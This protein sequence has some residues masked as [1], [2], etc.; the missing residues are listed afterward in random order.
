MISAG[1]DPGSNLDDLRL[2]LFGREQP[3]R[4]G[5]V[6]SGSGQQRSRYGSHL[7]RSGREKGDFIEFFATGADTEYSR[8]CVYW[9]VRRPGG[10]T[11]TIPVSNQISGLQAETEF[12][13]SVTRKDRVFYFAALRDEARSNFFGP[14]INNEGREQILRLEQ[15][16]RDS[17][18]RAELHISVQGATSVPHN[19]EVRL[20]GASVGT[21]QFEGV[22]P[23]TA[24]FQV[25]PLGLTNGDNTITLKAL[26]DAADIS[27]VDSITIRYPRFYVAV[28]DHLV[29]EVPA[30]RDVTI[31]GFIAGDI[32]VLDISD[33]EAVEELAGPLA[34]SSQGYSVTVSPR[35]G[36]DQT[37]TL[38]A[39]TT[40]W[41][42]TTAPVLNRPSAWNSHQQSADL[43]IITHGDFADAASQL[44]ALRVAQG[45]P[46]K[47]VD[48]ADVFDEFSF[49]IKDPTAIRSFLGHAKQN[50]KDAP[51][52]VLLFGDGSFDP[53]DRLGHG[54][55]DFVPTRMIAAN[56]LETASDDWFVDFS[57]LGF[58]EMAIGR[59]PVRT[60][61]DAE[62]LV[63][64]LAAYDRTGPGEEWTRKGVTIADG[65]DLKNFSFKDT[66]IELESLF[67]PALQSDRILIGELDSSSA[68]A[69]I[70]DAMNSGALLVNYIGHGSVEVWTGEGL[71]DIDDAR[72]LTNGSK[73][74]VVVSLN[75]LNGFF[76]EVVTDTVAEALLT[77]PAGGAVGVIA[78][79]ALSDPFGQ[80]ALARSFYQQLFAPESPTLGEALAAAKK[81]V[82]DEEV[83][84]TFLLL[85]DPTMRLR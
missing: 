16:N 25:D 29:M 8:E 71:F 72:A 10:T 41:A 24:S 20:N 39:F 44:A 1:F 84:R 79:S 73:T 81:N 36:A 78:S 48:V 45:F 34:H 68:R 11:K 50:W 69:R 2:Y 75:C 15:L 7:G 42:G 23:K 82:R 21:V 32:R 17:Q 30:G 46:T 12:L 57:G 37:R 59:L 64:K 67:G 18:K 53:L 83:R 65:D 6:Q 28:E 31:A 27:L 38:Y 33:P 14:V 47:I 70:L 63:Q 58:P 60:A 40:H 61:A 9:L 77:A 85:G 49:G 22:L 74:P 5:E 26:G 51:Q 56:F 3:I 35:G 54:F 66:A 4:V 52:H 55:S 19:L 43:V 13:S 76:E 80:A 62:L